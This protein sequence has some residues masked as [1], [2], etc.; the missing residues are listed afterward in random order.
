MRSLL[1]ICVSITLYINGASLPWILHGGQCLPLC[2]V[3]GVTVE[4][5]QR[6]QRGAHADVEG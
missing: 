2:N 3:T 1:S 5:S 6:S 4:M